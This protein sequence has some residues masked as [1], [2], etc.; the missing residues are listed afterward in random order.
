MLFGAATHAADVERYVVQKGAV[1]EQTS[2]A[3]PTPAAGGPYVFRGVTEGDIFAIID[4]TV[5]TPIGADLVLQLDDTGSFLQVEFPMPSLSALNTIAPNGTYT[6]LFDSV[7]VAQMNLPNASFPTA[8][9]QISNFAAAQTVNSEADF[10][11]TFNNFGTADGTER[12]ELQ[13]AEGD[14]W[15]ALQDAGFG[16]SVT[17]PEGSLVPGAIYSARLR[18]VKEV[19]RDTTS[20]PGAI[21]AI[22]LYNE[23][24][25]TIKTNGEGGG[26][27]DTTPPTLFITQPASGATDV[28]LATFVSFIFS[29]PM[30][31]AE[32]I[33]WSS[34]IDPAKVM[35]TWQQGMALV[36]TYQ[37]GWPGSSTITWKLNPSAANANFEDMAGNQLPINQFQGTF[38]T[39][40][41]GN[42]N[43]PCNGGGDDGRGG[44]TIF[45]SL[46]FVQ[47]GNAAPVPDSEMEA[48]F[49]A[50]YNAGT[51]QTVSSVSL[52]WPAG[53]TALGAFFG[54]WFTNATFDTAS[55]LEAAFPAGNYTMTV[56]GTGGGTATLAV[57]STA[58]VPFPRVANL[59]ALSTM[60]VSN[61]F[62][63]EF[64][65]FTGAGSTDGIFIQISG[66]EGQ[67]EFTAPDPC[68][69]RELPNTATSVVIPANTFKRGQTY[70]G[71]I[72]FSKAGQNSSTIPN[73]TIVAGSSVRTAFEF[74]I[75]GGST[76]RQPMWAGVVRNQDGTLTYTIQGDTGIT[77]SIEGSDAADSGWAQL[78]TALLAAGSHQFT[79]D[80]RLAPKKFLRARVL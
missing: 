66:E 41:G 7:T 22:E 17:L 35:Y 77:V 52:T 15:V 12:W 27:E 46:N 76:P 21:G 47:V 57:G 28:E 26:G 42:P 62:T 20:Y 34:N 13:I 18:F 72:T 53:T 25:F 56:A 24:Q 80:P 1:Y 55:A 16:G 2:A 38:T 19:A 49:G 11:L 36:A 6:Y 68:V 37:G 69:P 8:I 43:D 54:N 39:K 9:P 74:T 59:T 64:A 33:E 44:G 60:N 31:A 23:T 10:T 32:S 70:Q 65:A 30:A 73:T 58:Q 79:I 14:G 71:S 3:A 50:F 63:L 78:T 61:A 48:S 40:A 67:G 5:R 4:A 51:N 45:K 29:E 75:A